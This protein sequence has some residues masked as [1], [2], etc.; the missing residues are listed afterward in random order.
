MLWTKVSIL[1]VIVGARAGVL[2]CPCLCLCVPARVHL[3]VHVHESW[4]ADMCMCLGQIVVAY[5]MPLSRIAWH[6]SLSL[7]FLNSFAFWS[8]AARSV[9]LLLVKDI[10]SCCFCL[11]TTSS[12]ESIEAALLQDTV[13]FG[14]PRSWLH[15]VPSL[16]IPDVVN[17]RLCSSKQ[18]CV[19]TDIL[20]R[21]MAQQQSLWIRAMKCLRSACM[22]PQTFRHE[23]SVARWTFPWR[24]AWG[25]MSISG[26]GTDV[27]HHLMGNIV[28]KLGCQNALTHMH[29]SLCCQMPGANP[30][31]GLRG[32]RYL[33][34]LF[35]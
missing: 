15:C 6:S 4:C 31:F 16:L 17:E 11:P 8:C 33:G 1:G 21:A 13:N 10:C 14:V 28:R 34:R 23:S 19:G 29:A 22:Q 26:G 5:V 25:M 35:G 27:L 20:S 3:H 9:C 32:T 12:I 7:G 30:G 18:T 24:M 2:A